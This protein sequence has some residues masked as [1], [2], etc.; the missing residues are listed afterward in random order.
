MLNRIFF[1]ETRDHRR[2]EIG[3]HSVDGVAIEV[4]D[5][6]VSIVES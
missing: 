2:I 6:A 4:D 5:P 1:E 3:P